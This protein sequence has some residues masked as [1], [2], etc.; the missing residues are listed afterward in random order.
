ME[1]RF[2][3][4]RIGF[5]LVLS[6][7]AS[8]IAINTSPSGALVI[9]DGKG[10][11]Y[12]PFILIDAKLIYS[13]TRISIRKK[14]YRGV[15]TTIAKNRSF[16]FRYQSELNLKLQPLPKLSIDSA[17]N[18]ADE[19]LNQKP[20]VTNQNEEYYKANNSSEMIPIMVFAGI[21]LF[22]AAWWLTV[23]VQHP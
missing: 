3:L 22:L 14:G 18:S 19:N 8:S 20:I 11:G 5:L 4:L 6:G 9:V 13:R 23:T 17:K 16:G 10:N 1:T 12:T 7:C 21:G 15:D 2:L